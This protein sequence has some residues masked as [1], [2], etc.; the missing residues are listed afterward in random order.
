MRIA[1]RRCPLCEAA[2]GLDVHLDGDRVTAVRG[3]ATAVLS[4]GYICSKGAALAAI[5]TDPDRLHRPLVRRG[6]RHV[7]VSWEEAFDE[8]A[9][10]L[11]P[12][13]D[14]SGGGAVAVY[15]GNPAGSTDSA[16][17]GALNQALS[18]R[19]FYSAASVDGA[20]KGFAS[21]LL[22]GVPWANAVPD[23][24]RTQHLVIVGANPV[25][26]N[27]SILTAPNMPARLRAIRARGGKVV[28]L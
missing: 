6:D 15:S 21:G 20:A 1:S 8:V 28:V 22:L 2:C 19:H 18:T 14:T 10:R 5:D 24:D 4:E 25:D 12:V 23:V 9:S 13:L 3:R 17:R 26:S 27:G 7:E 16:F 11:R